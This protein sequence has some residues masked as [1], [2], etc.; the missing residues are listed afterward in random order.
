MNII[1]GLFLQDSWQI[2]KNLRLNYGL[3]WNAQFFRGPF[4][5]HKISIT[6]QLQPRIGAIY[7]AG[8]SGRYKLTAHFGRYYATFPLFTVLEKILPFNNLGLGYVADPRIP[9][10]E[11]VDT[12][13]NVPGDE[14]VTIIDPGKIRGEFTDEFV[15]GFEMLLEPKLKIGIK[16][17]FRHLKNGLQTYIPSGD[18]LIVGNPG[19][20]MLETLPSYKRKYAAL[21]LSIGTYETS[22]IIFFTSYVL[23]VNKG[24]YTG[25]FDQDN[26]Q[27]NK[28]G[29]YQGLQVPEQVPNSYG[30]MPNDRRH[31]FKL[32]ASYRFKFGLTAGT[33]F[34]IMS[35][36][37]YNEF[38]ISHF[39]AQ[40]YVYLVERGTAGRLP[41]LWDLNLRFTYDFD[42]ASVHGKIFLD[43]LHV[44]SPMET[45][46]VD[47][48]KFFDYE[49]TLPNENY[50]NVLQY[51]PPM[52]IRIGLNIDI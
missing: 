15:A 48:E 8:N 19:S 30:Y 7:Y 51:Q 39:G 35:G 11:P 4:K 28:P 14:P 50:G 43:A 32:N 37:P 27:I 49:M 12:I 34:W 46:K 10:T 40:R 24:N 2:I 3:R 45:V 36:T 1:P 41:T 47:E 20:G 18:S 44:G 23:S 21:E 38:G 52:M 22:R 42:F 25:F 5:D 16:G 33:S 26:G 6:D 29:E 9:G 17:I 31:V 13:F